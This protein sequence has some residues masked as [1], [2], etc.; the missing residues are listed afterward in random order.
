MSALSPSPVD[1]SFALH[2]A[3]AVCSASGTAFND[4]VID[5]NGTFVSGNSI[6]A[7][8]Q[9]T[10]SSPLFF[11]IDTSL[12]PLY[13]GSGTGITFNPGTFAI[14]D[15]ATDGEGTLAIS[16]NSTSP[17]PEAATWA[18]LL[19]GAAMALAAGRFTRSSRRTIA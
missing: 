19:T 10:L 2:S 18:L 5:E 1:F 13:S 16:A 8:S 11:W 17:T 4:I 3:T 14:V 6:G 15:G 9:T 7:T 12:E